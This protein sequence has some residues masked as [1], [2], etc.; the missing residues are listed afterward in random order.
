MLTM[1]TIFDRAL[2]ELAY[3][4]HQLSQRVNYF[5]YNRQFKRTEYLKFEDIPTW[6]KKR[7]LETLY[8]MASTLPRGAY[9]LEIGSYLGASTCYLA[10]G[11]SRIGGHLFCVDTWMN[12][13]ML[14]G[15]RD[16][17]SE[18]LKNTQSVRDYITPIRKRSSELNLEDIHPPLHL[19]FIDGDHNYLAVKSDF[20][21]VAAWVAKDGIIAFHDSNVLQYEGVSRVIGEAL[22][23]G[24]WKVSGAIE[25]LLWLKPFC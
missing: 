12:E 15:D 1:N 4:L 13:T 5:I 14:E 22:L 18:F 2:N 25:S 20:E 10:S 3:Q 24:E 21:R 6:T 16:T 11:L 8:Y 9:A 23:T 19:V 7:E 17:Y